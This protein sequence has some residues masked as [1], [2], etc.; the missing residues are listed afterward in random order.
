V[1]DDRLCVHGTE[2]LRRRRPVVLLRAV[3]LLP[4]YV[5]LWVWA[6]LLVPVVPLSWLAAIFTGRVPA[7]CHRFLA[8]F[9]RYE[10]QVLAWLYLLSGK[11]PDPLHTQEHPFVIDVPERSRQRRLATFFR[12]PLA[13][14]PV[15]L[16]SV[17]NVILSASSVGAWIV[18]LALGRTTA[19]LQELGTFCLRY[20]LE[21]QAYLLLV[22]SRY[23]KL[24]PSPA[25]FERL[26]SPG[27]E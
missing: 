26:P 9:L 10:G 13:V 19:G 3:L 27:P 16:A 20:Q 24:E 4:H 17:F 21:T 5:V 18:A 23:P 1:P 7:R 12:L 22:T 25:P 15:V 8:A 2:R 6:L 14:P 11:Y